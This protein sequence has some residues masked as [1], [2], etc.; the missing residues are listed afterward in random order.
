MSKE[1]NQVKFL[2]FEYINAHSCSDEIMCKR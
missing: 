2:A 1:Q